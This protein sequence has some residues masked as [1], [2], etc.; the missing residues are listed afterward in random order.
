L[1]DRHRHLAALGFLS[2]AIGSALGSVTGDI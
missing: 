2:G 1:P